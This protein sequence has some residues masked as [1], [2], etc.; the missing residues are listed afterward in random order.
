[1]KKC[2]CYKRSVAM[3]TVIIAVILTNPISVFGSNFY[4]Y[5]E[6]NKIELNPL[7]SKIVVK[8]RPEMKLLDREK[9]LTKFGLSIDEEGGPF[10]LSY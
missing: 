8:F 2:I 7:P 5:S 6:N 1:M 4:F 9:L 10:E 3:V